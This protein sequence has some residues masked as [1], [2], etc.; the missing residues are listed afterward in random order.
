M[1]WPVSDETVDDIAQDEG[2]VSLTVSLMCCPDAAP[3]RN[4]NVN[5]AV[6]S[7]ESLPGCCAAGVQRSGSSVSQLPH[8]TRYMQY[9]KLSQRPMLNITI[10]YDTIMLKFDRREEKK[11]SFEYKALRL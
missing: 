11:M 6:S 9:T 2:H 3:S 10:P 7:T 1:T 8:G 4:V 5:R